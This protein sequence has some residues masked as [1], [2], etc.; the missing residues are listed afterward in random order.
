MAPDTPDAEA[1]RFFADEDFNYDI[2]V[3][4]RRA[5]PSI[6]IV[7]AAEAGTLRWTDPEVLAWAA[8]HNRILLSHDKRTMPDHF[9]R[10]LAQ[11]SP[12]IHS[13]GVMLLPQELAIGRCIAAVLEIWRLSAHDEWRDLLIRLPL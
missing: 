7:T 11:L 1:P 3:G 6:D 4:L 10:F 9:Y 2:V 8:A 13:S 12:G 5:E